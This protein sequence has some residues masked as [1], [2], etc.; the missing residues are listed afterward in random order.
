M[1]AIIEETTAMDTTDSA[2]RLDVAQKRRLE[3]DT[4]LPTT[5]GS[6]GESDG[7]EGWAETKSRLEKKTR[8]YPQRPV[9]RE[10]RTE[11]KAGPKQS[12]GNAQ[13][14]KRKKSL[15]TERDR[16]TLDS[17]RLS[18]QRKPARSLKR[19]AKRQTM[20]V[21]PIHRKPERSA[22]PRRSTSTM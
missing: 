5:S 18:N 20:G 10:N 9:Q 8:P 11:K 21:K 19:L 6:E 13:I 7:E 4:A 22:V 2:S 1:A 16:Q 14:L 12:R 15:L 3:E 17:L